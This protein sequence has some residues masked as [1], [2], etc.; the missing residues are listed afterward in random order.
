MQIY[1]LRIIITQISDTE[2]YHFTNNSSND[3]IFYQ[4]KNL[5]NQRIVRQMKNSKITFKEN[6]KLTSPLYNG[7]PVKHPSKDV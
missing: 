5:L 4:E 3:M 6:L 7:I 2:I 1:N